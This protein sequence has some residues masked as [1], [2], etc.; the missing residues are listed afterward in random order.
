MNEIDNK[1]VKLYHHF[2][3]VH[4]KRLLLHHAPL[5]NTVCAASVIMA[6][7]EFI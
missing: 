5:R 2:N 6:I 7:V 4:S 1:F 3:I